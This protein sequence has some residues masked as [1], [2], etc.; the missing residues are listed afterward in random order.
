MEIAQAYSMGKLRAAPSKRGMQM[1]LLRK[2]QNCQLKH[3]LHPG[4]ASPSALPRDA[5]PQAPLRTA[6]AGSRSTR[7]VGSCLPT[8]PA[9][10]LSWEQLPSSLLHV[11]TGVLHMHWLTHTC[12]LFP[13]SPWILTEAKDEKGWPSPRGKCARYK[14]TDHRP[15]ELE[16]AVYLLT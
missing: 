4:L 14:P 11:Q 12:V 15:A 16:S 3:C 8:Q 13:F 2:A 6:R 9:A 5:G 10:P 7:G 1:L